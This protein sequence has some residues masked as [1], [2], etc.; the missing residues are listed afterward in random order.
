[1]IN[2]PWERRSTLHLDNRVKAFTV[3][4]AQWL[5]SML[6]KGEDQDQL[7]KQNKT[8]PGSA[9]LFAKQASLC[10]SRT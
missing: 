8:C 3:R 4:A 1:M 6:T 10:W 7:K 9:H 2:G 5:Q